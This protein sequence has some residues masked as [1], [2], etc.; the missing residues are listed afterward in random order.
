MVRLEH[1][2]TKCPLLGNL[3][4]NLA[5]QDRSLDAQSHQEIVLR[6]QTFTNVLQGQ[7]DDVEVVHNNSC[8]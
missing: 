3:R 6:L 2:A 4:R 1:G 5:E 7:C 8:P